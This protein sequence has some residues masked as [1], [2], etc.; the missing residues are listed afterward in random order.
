MPAPSPPRP[1]CDFPAEARECEPH[2]RLFLAIGPLLAAGCR[3]L[4]DIHRKLP[5]VGRRC[6]S[7]IRLLPDRL[8]AL[9][10]LAF[11]HPV[12]LYRTRWPDGGAVLGLTA[13]GRVALRLTTE[14]LAGLDQPGI[15]A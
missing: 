3:S 14:Y 13:E 10:N 8:Q 9:L 11:G 2:L 1:F 15:S 4:W 12:E 5:Q 7:T 6:Y